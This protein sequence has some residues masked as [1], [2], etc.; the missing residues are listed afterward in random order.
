MASGTQSKWG[1]M[2]ATQTTQ[3]PAEQ[4]RRQQRV[5]RGSAGGPGKPLAPAELSPSTGTS[6]LC[7]GEQAGAR[8]CLQAGS[9]WGPQ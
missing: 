2:G 4:S 7:R 5:H 8:G 9:I 3:G 1:E 6:S